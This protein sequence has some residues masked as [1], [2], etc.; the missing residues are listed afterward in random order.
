MCEQQTLFELEVLTKYT[1]NGLECNH[2]GVVQPVENFE[3]VIGKKEIKRA[4][5]SCRKKQKKIINR[6]KKENAYPDENYQCPICERTLKEV[7][8]LG[9]K[10]LQSWVLDH[11]HKSQTFR[12]WLCSNCNTGLGGFKDKLDR[13]KRAVLYLEKHE[14]SLDE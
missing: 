5:N 8:R 14:E 7:S 3:H 12:G 10:M 11:C 6:L 2:C 9:Q 1:E 13:V 4:C